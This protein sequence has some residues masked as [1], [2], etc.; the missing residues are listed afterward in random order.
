MFNNLD[1]VNFF[2]NHKDLNVSIKP[3]EIDDNALKQSGNAFDEANL[4]QELELSDNKVFDE[5]NFG[6]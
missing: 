6:D 4:Y 1:G 5:M 2:A 3:L